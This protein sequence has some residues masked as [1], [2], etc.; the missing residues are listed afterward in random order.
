L[1]E[2]LTP[3]HRRLGVDAVL[4]QRRIE[5]ATTRRVSAGSLYIA[6]VNSP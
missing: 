5:H 2:V 1:R 6:G 4:S 3:H